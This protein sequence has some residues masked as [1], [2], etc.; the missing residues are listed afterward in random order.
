MRDN[1]VEQFAQLLS[2]GPVR[3]EA[4]WVPQRF[5]RNANDRKNPTLNYLVC[6]SKSDGERFTCEYQAG[7]GHIKRHPLKRHEHRIPDAEIAEQTT[8]PFSPKAADIL[9]CL[10]SEMTDEAFEDWCSNFGYDTDSQKARET[11]DACRDTTVKLG[12]IL[13][14]QLVSD[15]QELFQDY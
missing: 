14:P 12:R 6:I 15:L 13:G 7:M 4:L 5:S 3:V 10:I 2:V 8:K 11:Y 9:Y 1:F